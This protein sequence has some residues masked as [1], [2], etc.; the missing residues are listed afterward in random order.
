[1]NFVKVKTNFFLEF[2]APKASGK[3][4]GGGELPPL[5]M[6]DLHVSEQVASFDPNANYL[7]IGFS[8][9]PQPGGL[10]VRG[11]TTIYCRH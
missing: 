7:G 4:V 2:P 1:L 8:Y 11:D 3:D 6:T 10:G 5:L 9:L